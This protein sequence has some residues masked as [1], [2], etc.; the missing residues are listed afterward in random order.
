M[1]AGRIVLTDLGD[2]DNMKE[3]DYD[4]FEG[5]EST[6]SYTYTGSSLTLAHDL[7][8]WVMFLSPVNR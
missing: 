8:R 2:S 7:V 3:G 4:T 5:L 6:E 1:V